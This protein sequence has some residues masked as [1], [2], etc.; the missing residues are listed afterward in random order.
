MEEKVQINQRRQ[1]LKWVAAGI[2]LSPFFGFTKSAFRPEIPIE[3]KDKWMKCKRE[4]AMG[5]PEH[6]ALVDDYF[7]PVSI[8]SWELDDHGYRLKYMNKF[9]HQLSF[10][11]SENSF[12]HRISIQ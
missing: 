11:Q 1:L 5:L 6:P 12:V 2:A 3:A 10:D 8:S 7:N 4:Y 9:G